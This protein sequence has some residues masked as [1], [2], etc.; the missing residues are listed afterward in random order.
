MPTISTASQQVRLSLRIDQTPG[1]SLNY[2][3]S[4]NALARDA[5]RLG[6]CEWGGLPC[7]AAA[8][9]LTDTWTHAGPISD[10]PRSDLLGIMD[11]SRQV[12]VVRSR[13]RMR[14]T[15]ILGSIWFHFKSKDISESH[16]TPVCYG[17]PV[18][19]SLRPHGFDAGIDTRRDRVSK[20]CCMIP[21][22]KLPVT[23]RGGIRSQDGRNQHSI[24]RSSRWFLR[25]FRADLW[26]IALR[27]SD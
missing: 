7:R 21:S 12:F 1:A 23:P 20:E 5:E 4:V 8:S 9:R 13:D 24:Y 27:S 15:G 26:P 2:L 18:G 25:P 3:I 11:L 16:W 22:L 14:I 19:R 6:P 17:S 10:L